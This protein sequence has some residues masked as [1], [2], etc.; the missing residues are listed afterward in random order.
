V[1]IVSDTS[2]INY[3]IL[4]EQ[5]DRLYDLY[6]RVL[7]PPSVYRELQ[8]SAAPSA[9]RLWLSS[10]PAWFEVTS[11]SETAAS[12]LDYLG[13]SERDAIL[14]AKELGADGLL[15]DDRDGRTEATRRD[16]RVIG[17]LGVLAAA[18]EK[19]LLDLPEVIERLRRTTFRAS[20]ELF[21]A[22]L[23]RFEKSSSGSVKSKNRRK[24]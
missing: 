1:I 20:P 15:I 23:E 8:A 3:L 12:Q 13:A 21:G 7:V 4:I 14:L 9:V 16:L 17:T 10:Q 19:E 6:R 22:L 18:A 5:I 11:H 2:P 24:K